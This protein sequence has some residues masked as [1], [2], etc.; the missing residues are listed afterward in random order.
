VQTLL[1]T[2][3]E[4]VGEG[5]VSVFFLKEFLFV[6]KV[7]IIHWKMSQKWQSSLSKSSYRSEIKYKSLITCLFVWL[8]NKN[9]IY[10][11]GDFNLFFPPLTS[12]N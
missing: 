5:W 11:Y 3:K 9:Q 2:K 1:F 10:G 6:A 4:P 12:S 8:H 7:V